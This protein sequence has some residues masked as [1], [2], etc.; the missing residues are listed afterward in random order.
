MNA[1]ELL[2]LEAKVGAQLPFSQAATILK[3]LLPVDQALNAETLRTHLYKIA[4]RSEKERE[5]ETS[6]SRDS[7]IPAAE[8]KTGRPSPPLTV[9]IDG[10]YVR[11]KDDRRNHFEMIVGKS[12]PDEGGNKVFGFVQAVDTDP[13]CRLHELLKSQNMQRN[14]Q[15]T[16]L[17]DGGDTVRDIQRYLHPEAEHLLDWFHVTMRITVLTNCAK[18]IRHQNPE[19]GGKLLKLVERTKWKLW[20]GNV[21][22]GLDSIEEIIFDLEAQEDV[23]KGHKMLKYASEFRTYIENNAHFIPNYGER[24]RYGE[25]ISTGFAESTVNT[26][27]AKRFNKRQQMQWTKQGAHLLLQVRV[28]TVNGELDGLFRDWYPGFR[29]QHEMPLAA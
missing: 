15:V 18:G 20:H 1:P 25:R 9:G 7:G 3:E 24:Y 23:G 5:K 19:H 28:K 10:G 26:L 6:H 16:F 2:Y 14:Q 13:K 12:I 8:K 29:P 17:S 21:C 11:D 27:I 22:D 4:E